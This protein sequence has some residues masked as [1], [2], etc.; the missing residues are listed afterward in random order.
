MT[1][2]RSSKPRDR[3]KS[4][5]CVAMMVAESSKTDRL[6]ARDALRCHTLR[7]KRKA[8]T[9]GS[10]EMILRLK[11]KRRLSRQMRRL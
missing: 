8:A 10:R 3:A 7:A 1:K 11:K 9:R 5:G 6:R 2:K 4:A